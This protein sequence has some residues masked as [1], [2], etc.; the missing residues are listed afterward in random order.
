M[1]IKEDFSYMNKELVDKEYAALSFHSIRFHR[2]FTEQEMEQNRANADTMSRE[3]WSYACKETSKKI[4][5]Q[6]QH[7]LGKLLN[8]KIYQLMPEVRYDSNYDLFFWSNG[9]FNDKTFDYM[10]LSANDRRTPEENMQLLND[11]LQIVKD[12]DVPN[13]QCIV[14]YTEIPNVKMIRSRALGIINDIQGKTISYKGIQGKIKRVTEGNDVDCFGLFKNGAR[15]RYYVLD[16]N[17]IVL[18]Y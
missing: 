9:D 11:V 17:Y 1:K 16:E 6:L 12:I 4:Y 5:N 2:Y 10:T 3:E 8:Y 15:R 13:V 18:N 14:Q 7:V